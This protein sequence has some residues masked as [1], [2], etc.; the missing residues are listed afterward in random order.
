MKG[1]YILLAFSLF[2]TMHDIYLLLLVVGLWKQCQ[3]YC[4]L[5]VLYYSLFFLWWTDCFM[6]LYYDLWCRFARSAISNLHNEN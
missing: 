4:I 3:E 2:Y 1:L 5:Y 6:L